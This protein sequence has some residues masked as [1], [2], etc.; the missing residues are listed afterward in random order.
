[1]KGRD[2]KQA[3]LNADLT[4]NTNGK[5][6][7][8]RP[9]ALLVKAGLVEHDTPWIVHKA[10]YGLRESPKAWAVSRD[11][12]LRNFVV[13]VGARM[14]TLEQSIADP[15]SWAVVN[16]KGKKIGIVIVYVD[17]IVTTGP[18]ELVDEI[19]DW[20]GRTWACTEVHSIDDPDGMTFCSIVIIR[21]SASHG[22]TL[23][24]HKYIKDLVQRH[25]LCDANPLPLIFDKDE[26][27][28]A[29]DPDD[30]TMVTAEDVRCAQA[31]TGELLSGSTRTRPDISYS[32]N[33]MASLTGK[34]PRRAARMGQRILRYL[35]GTMS[36]GRFY[37]DDYETVRIQGTSA[38]TLE[39]HW[40][41]QALVSY[42][43][44]SYAPE[45]AKSHG[46]FVSVWA[47]A[48]VFWRNGKQAF[49]VMSTACRGRAHGSSRSTDCRRV[50]QR[51]H[52][53]ASAYSQ[54][55][56]RHRQHSVGGATRRRRRALEDE[57]LAHPRFS[58]ARP[59][60]PRSGG[61]CPRR[62]S[63][64][65][66]RLPDQTF[67]APRVKELREQWLLRSSDNNN[68]K[69]K[70]A[71]TTTTNNN[72]KSALHFAVATPLPT[73]SAAQV[74]VFQPQPV[75]FFNEALGHRLSSTMDGLAVIASIF[76]IAYVASKAYKAA[77][78][79]QSHGFDAFVYYLLGIYFDK[80]CQ[81]DQ[82]EPELDEIVV[83]C[84]RRGVV[85]TQVFH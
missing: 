44:I 39:A 71:T 2:I 16:K 74:V 11:Q 29:S 76:A 18:E 30:E 49:P 37:P 54:A 72:V 77:R 80:G 33:R 4:H 19:M 9:P 1:M 20:V 50:S 42:T 82:T 31:V 14:F 68:V 53:R 79:G 24:P 58:F 66:G 22:I 35:L 45:G 3:F 57:A 73:T 61:H 62:W 46:G 60:R 32:V 83:A 59:L 7:L 63:T 75:A 38:I 15:N 67:P 85:S 51:H 43:G 28:L 70:K 69:A 47:A 34:E 40:D 8:V 12:K 78:F 13:T 17:D 36:V 27:A 10:L 81:T 6:I 64:A 84:D 23:R 56:S 25:G 26:C 52:Q 48:P 65:V 21:T 5:R 41:F 55:D